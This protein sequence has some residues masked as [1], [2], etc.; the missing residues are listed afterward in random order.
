MF[1]LQHLLQTIVDKADVHYVSNPHLPRMHQHKS[2]LR[3][4]A[5]NDAVP[6][7][8]HPRGC[9]TRRNDALEYRRVFPRTGGVG[10][11]LSDLFSVFWAARRYPDQEVDKLAFLLV[12]PVGV[13]VLK[14]FDGFGDIVFERHVHAEALG[15][16]YENRP[17]VP[18]AQMCQAYLRKGNEEVT[19]L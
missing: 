12:G 14:L 16:D 13:N 19:S 5:E 2:K 8:F 3:N 18:Y 9:S 7:S 11:H 10:Q 1:R 17:P 6:Q 15:P 4:A